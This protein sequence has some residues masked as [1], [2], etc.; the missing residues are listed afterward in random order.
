MDMVCVGYYALVCCVFVSWV[1]VL[2]VPV[3][4][5]DGMLIARWGA[6]FRRISG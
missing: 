4:G 3:P 2:E 5:R 1:G 6:K